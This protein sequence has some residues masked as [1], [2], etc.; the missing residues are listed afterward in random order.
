MEIVLVDDERVTLKWLAHA[1]GQL[2]E[3]YH[4]CASFVHAGKAL[5]YCKENP[6]DILITDIRMPDLD[7]LTLLSMLQETNRMP[8][9]IIVSAYSDFQFAKEALRL[10][11]AQYL[12]KPE[13]TLQSLQS[14]LHDAYQAL[15]AK[16]SAQPNEGFRFHNEL[17]QFLDA[18][19]P[20][21]SPLCKVSA[22]EYFCVLLHAPSSADLP[23]IAE[24]SYTFLTQNSPTFWHSRYDSQTLVYVFAQDR[25]TSLFLDWSQMLASFCTPHYYL[26]SSISTPNQELL[27]RMYAQSQETLATLLFH[28]LSGWHSP[29][30]EEAEILKHGIARIKHSCTTILNAI[31]AETFP[32]IGPEF[33]AMVRAMRK[34]QMPP[35]TVEKILQTLVFEIMHRSNDQTSLQEQ[36]PLGKQTFEQYS[37]QMRTNIASLTRKLEEKA[38][39]H[40]YSPAV[41]QMILYGRCHLSERISLETLSDIVHLNKNYASW[42]FSKE[43]GRSFSSWLLSTRLDRAKKLLAG[44]SEKINTIA[45]QVGFGDVAYFS[46]Q[47]HKVHGL[48]PS[49]YRK[50]HSTI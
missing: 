45:E 14:S 49:E 47:F 25:D 20:S 11:A 1:I 10:G 4:V 48:T 50:H 43:V 37:S 44:T 30:A 27:P 8:Y 12:L 19:Q 13:M 39:L 15:T 41:Q 38:L 40:A 24:I 32:A 29:R 2:G 31:E 23:R 3:L 16:T 6:V 7:G 26:V 22:P 35:S 33:D 42:L 28:E 17:L 5:A 9:T 18:S 21:F 34:Y 36:E 46:K